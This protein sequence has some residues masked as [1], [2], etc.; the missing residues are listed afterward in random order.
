MQFIHPKV[1][2]WMHYPLTW[3]SLLA[4]AVY[5]GM[6][7]GA[8]CESWEMVGCP[9][10]PSPLGFSPREQLPDITGC[11]PPRAPP[12]H[13]YMDSLAKRCVNY[14]KANGIEN[15]VDVFCY[16]QSLIV[17]GRPLDV[18]DVTVSLE[19]ETNF[20]LI[21][22][23]DV[24]KMA[25]EEMEVLKDQRLTL[26]VGFMARVLKITVALEKSSF[27]YVYERLK[28]RTLTMV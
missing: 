16:A 25:M 7:L 24:L 2:Q 5:R 8:T 4:E 22:Q 10:C 23:Q 3:F 19:G 21:N 13:P 18:W 17:T 6:A 20:I 26:T 14:C 28:L 11:A 27:V 9:I 15:P 12:I 1:V